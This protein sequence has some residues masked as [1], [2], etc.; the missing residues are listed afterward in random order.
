M[1]D[2]RRTYLLTRGLKGWLALLKY[3]KLHQADPQALILIILL[4]FGLLL[5]TDQCL[6]HGIELL[7]GVLIAP[8]I[9]VAAILVRLFYP[10]Q[11][12]SNHL[13]IYQLAGQRVP[14]AC[15]IKSIDGGHYVPILLPEQ[16]IVAIRAPSFLQLQLAG[17]GL[18]EDFLHKTRGVC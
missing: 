6:R 5:V 1:T 17:E 9:L 8:L 3:V 7:A 12:I 16:V 13:P 2:L 15:H 10:L 14:E 18:S 4:N 11:V